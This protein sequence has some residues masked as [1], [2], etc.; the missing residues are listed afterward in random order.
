[1]ELCKSYCL[2]R[3]DRLLIIRPL[4]SLLSFGL[5][6]V[7]TFEWFG[8]AHFS[9]NWGIISLSPVLAGNIFNLLFGRIYDSHVPK[10]GH[11]H[12]CPDG[13]EC[14]RSVFELTTIAAIFATILSFIIIARKADRP[15]WIRSRFS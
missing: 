2:P 15:R 9:Q 5:C 4:N 8:L 10:E 3:E 12:L 6:P 13:E 11:V 7:L 1:M 14:F